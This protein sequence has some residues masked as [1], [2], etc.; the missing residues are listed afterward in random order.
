LPVRFLAPRKRRQL[1]EL[2]MQS[3]RQTHW[4]PICWK[5]NSQKLMMKRALS[6]V[7]TWQPIASA[8]RVG[9]VGAAVEEVIELRSRIHANI[10]AGMNRQVPISMT[11]NQ[12]LR[13]CARRSIRSRTLA[14]MS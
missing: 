2:T 14:P 11:P 8:A 7:R 13:D 10:V 3:P 6:K 12:A 4:M 5:I 1:T 9:V